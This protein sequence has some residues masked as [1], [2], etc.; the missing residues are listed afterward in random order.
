MFLLL[1][2]NE[3]IAERRKNLVSDKQSKTGIALHMPIV[4]FV[5]LQTVRSEL[6]DTR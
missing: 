4:H 2:I 6:L 3:R 1:V 5:L